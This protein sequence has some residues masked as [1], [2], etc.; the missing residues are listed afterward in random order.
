[1]KILLLSCKT[2]GGHDAAANAL[3]EQ[4][5]KNGHEA[6]VFDYL[7][8]ASEKTAKRVADFYVKTVQIA[9]QAFGCAY[10]A[11]QLLG[12]CVKRSPIYYVN[13]KMVKHLTSYLEKN[14]YDAIV[15]THLYPMETI[16]AM[17]RKG[18]KLP[19]T[20][21]VMTDYTVIPFICET[22]V[23]EYIAPHPDLIEACVKGGLK[24]ERLHPFGIP[25]T[26]R[27]LENLSKEQAAKKLG[28]D[29]NK[30]IA[31]LIGGSMGAGKLCSLAK[32]FYVNEQ[33]KGLQIVIICGNNRSLKHKISEKVGADSRFLILGATNEMPLLM[34]A[35]DVVYTKPGGLTTTETAA[36]R[37]PMIITYPIPGCETANKS[38]F[39]E[40]GM[41]ASANSPEG[42]VTEGLALLNELEKTTQMI[43]AQEENISADATQKIA[44]FVLGL[45]PPENA[46]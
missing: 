2:G 11:A 46:D 33:T 8:L 20:V 27:L 31:L 13:A 26:P 18:I 21:A 9:P 44:N 3:K 25:Y 14:R 23:D 41:A 35:A 10:K 7:T 42:L 32:A 17:K 4:F 6:F 38:F 15:M 40:K 12:K 30:K 1:M 37:T 36:S 22:D 5:E 16:T 29:P 28:L 34:K 24:K 45:I 43:R 19:P 39:I